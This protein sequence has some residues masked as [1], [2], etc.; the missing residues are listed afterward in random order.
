MKISILAIYKRFSCRASGVS[1]Q[2]FKGFTFLEILVVLTLGILLM[3]MVVPQFFA[4]FSKAHES[5]FKHLSSVLKMLRN[6]AVLKST[7]YCL[8]FDL[9]TQQMM[10][11]EEDESGKC[12]KDILDNPKVL[13][14]HDFPEDLILSTA[15]LVGDEFS[16]SGTASDLLEVHINRSGFVSPFFLVYSLHD[17]SKSWIIES[18]GIMGKIQ[19]SEQ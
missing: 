16:S 7:A 6:D 17:S 3:G 13:K 10:T 12:G 19:L 1:S 5:E 15:N 18:K 8:I 9:K 11:T 2:R 4:M 14:P